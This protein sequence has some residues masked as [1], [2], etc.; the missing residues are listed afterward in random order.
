MASI[1]I[2]MS[3]CTQVDSVQQLAMLCST[4]KALKTYL[5]SEEGCKL[6]LN[7]AR[8]ICGDEYW[9]ETDHV[10]DGRY[11]AM[12]RLCPWLGERSE[13]PFTEYMRST[14]S[15]NSGMDRLRIMK[16]SVRF[17][18]NNDVS[19]YVACLVARPEF[20]KRIAC[21]F[22]GADHFVVKDVQI[23][24]AGLVASHMIQ[25][26]CEC[27]VFFE[28]A[29]F[30]LLK[31]MHSAHGYLR[32]SCG[33]MSVLSSDPAIM[34]RFAPSDT[35]IVPTLQDVSE[36][37]FSVLSIV[38]KEISPNGESNYK[39]SFKFRRKLGLF[40]GRCRDFPT[41]KVVSWPGIKVF[42]EERVLKQDAK[43][44]LGSIPRK[45]FKA[46]EYNGYFVQLSSDEEES[47]LGGHYYA[48]ASSMS[49]CV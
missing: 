45:T 24:H 10:K 22:P 37:L 39:E 2:L 21:V 43:N 36:Q 44:V 16:K 4:S 26:M 15:L 35:R 34:V 38:F 47:T 48:R 12:V 29:G 41:W 18:P 46:T 13:E 17:I 32:F 8:R 20:Q 31:V 33:I 23:V 42:V 40:L 49:S 25:G 30:R 27:V 28:T 5:Y 11:E 9:S 3:V 19:E 1:D 6:W 7:V 14:H